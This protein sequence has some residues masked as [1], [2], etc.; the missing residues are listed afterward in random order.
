[1]YFSRVYRSTLLGGGGGVDDDDATTAV[2]SSGVA[3]DSMSVIVFS[4]PAK[5]HFYTCFLTATTTIAA[6]S[7]VVDDMNGEE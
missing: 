3:D 4:F 5:V 6:S 1:M 7:T 2:G